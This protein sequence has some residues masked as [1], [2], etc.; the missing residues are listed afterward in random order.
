MNIN[1]G[2]YS[3]K[4]SIG[5]L[6]HMLAL[7]S[8]AKMCGFESKLVLDSGYDKFVSRKDNV[9][10]ISFYEMMLNDAFDVLIIYN[11]ALMDNIVL[12]K[13]KRN[14]P[15]I[16]VVF[17][18]HEPWTSISEEVRREKSIIGCI[19]SLGRYILSKRLLEKVDEIW[20]PSYNAYNKYERNVERK[21]LNHVI[22]PLVFNDEMDCNVEIK[23]E[24]F[25]F[26]STV[27]YQKRFK[28]F[29]SF[30]EYY[31]KKDK[32]VKFL[33]ATRSNIAKYIS[34]YMISLM[35]QGRLRIIHGRSLTIEEINMAY[36]ASW[37]TWL[38]YRSSTQSGV[39]AK[40]VM[41]GTPCIVSSIPAFKEYVKKEEWVVD[42]VNDFE[43]I[44]NKI[45]I[46]KADIDDNYIYAR[47]IYFE[48]FSVEGNLE[49]FKKRMIQLAK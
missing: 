49:R 46:I 11:I 25:S 3:G 38:L 32:T 1:I 8:M 13:L 21:K 42:D 43:G 18:Y 48:N 31:S 41:L 45:N 26:I 24:F 7:D 9:R 39:L 36:R 14:N 17:V 23:R 15:N 20:L 19:K 6:S 34:K 22:F 44:I 12:K 37:C 10:V 28:E 40:S 47:K 29:L 33:I 4:F 2:I 30:L 35:D 5:L 16:K 27:S